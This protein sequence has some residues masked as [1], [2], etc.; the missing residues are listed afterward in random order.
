MKNNIKIFSILGPICKDTLQIMMEIRL[1]SEKNPKSKIKI[2]LSSEGGEEDVGYAIFDTLLAIPN[3]VTIEG[4]GQVSSIAALIFQAADNRLLSPNTTL[5]M[6]NGVIVLD[7]Q[8]TL[9][10][11]KLQ[12]WARHYDKNNAKYYESIANRSK[13]PIEQV[14]KWCKAERFFNAFEAVENGLADGIVRKI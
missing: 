10:I 11:D 13:I 9:E 6:H 2:I 14:K 5:M 8:E 1:F 12:E 4:Y 3:N 7:G